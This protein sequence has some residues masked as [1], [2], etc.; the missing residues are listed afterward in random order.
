MHPERGSGP[1]QGPCPGNFLKVA[2][3]QGLRTVS[4]AVE[5]NRRSCASCGAK[6]HKVRDDIGRIRV[7]RQGPD[8]GI[9]D[10]VSGYD[11]RLRRI[12]ARHDSFVKSDEAAAS[13]VDSTARLK[14]FNREAVGER[15]SFANL[16]KHRLTVR[17]TQPAEFNFSPC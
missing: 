13:L 8:W 1:S 16:G 2:V 9:Q 14:V 5:K 17:L 12:N 10:D 4:S 15:R 11:N 6:R 7:S 3:K